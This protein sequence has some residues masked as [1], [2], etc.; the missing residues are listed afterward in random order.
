MTDNAAAPDA[1]ASASSPNS[2]SDQT[3]DTSG[4][5]PAPVCSFE[6]YAEW[7]GWAL[8]SGHSRLAFKTILETPEWSKQITKADS[9]Q[10]AQLHAL[11]RLFGLHSISVGEGLSRSITITKPQNWQPPSK[12]PKSI[13]LDIDLNR[14]STIVNAPDS[15]VFT[16]YFES[17]NGWK[18]RKPEIKALFKYYFAHLSSPENIDN[19][20]DSV[21]VSG[22]R[23]AQIHELRHTTLLLGLGDRNGA[24]SGQ[25]I[26]DKPY[27]FAYKIPEYALPF[28]SLSSKRGKNRNP[29][30]FDKKNELGAM[31]NDLECERCHKG[32]FH[33]TLVMGYRFKAGRAIICSD[34]W[35]ADPYLRGH[36]KET[37]DTLFMEG[38]AADISYSQRAAKR[39]AWWGNKTF[40][41][42]ID[43]ATSENLPVG[44]E[45][46]ALNLEICDKI[47][48]KEVQPKEAIRLLKKRL[49]H[50]NPNVQI[51]TVKVYMQIDGVH[52]PETV[53]KGQKQ[54][55]P[56]PPHS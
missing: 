9:T 18:A 54:I 21:I 12:L 3:N 45:D 33:C 7:D 52:E 47:K 5:P 36:K 22:L 20:Y 13:P 32:G 16:T 42:L 26:I 44:S 23:P 56:P 31:L 4:L 6:P 14:L 53:G 28:P 30:R 55:G 17:W 8:H 46:L 25:V 19:K 34:C 48:S 15:Q 29:E 41:E 2:G 24:S 27:G 51:L 1:T 11:S 37:Y 50:K 49:N 38:Y 35:E 10:R 43:R 40:E 39:M